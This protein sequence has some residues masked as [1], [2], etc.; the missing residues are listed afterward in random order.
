MQNCIFQNLEFGAIAS[1]SVVDVDDCTFLGNAVATNAN[2]FGYLRVRKSQFQ[3]NGIGVETSG[4][5]I[6]A[7]SANL[8]YVGLPNSL[9][10]NSTGV[11]ANAFDAAYNAQNNWWGSASGPQAPG[12]SSGQGD[13]ITGPGASGIAF[14]PFLAAA[15]N[16][17]NHPPVVRVREPY[18]PFLPVPQGFKPGTKV[19]LTWEA[20]DDDANL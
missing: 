6:G 13:S 5:L 4:A 14:N 3:G 19:I 20:S 8:S 17:N 9:A 15:P 16:F 7:G 12:N 10:G 18:L 1:E 11:L 2:T